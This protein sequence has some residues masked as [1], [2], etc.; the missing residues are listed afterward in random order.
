MRQGLGNISRDA[1]FFRITCTAYN[2]K[3]IALLGQKP[4]CN[5]EKCQSLVC[6]C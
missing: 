1:E 5:L 4:G 3:C 2:G 6:S